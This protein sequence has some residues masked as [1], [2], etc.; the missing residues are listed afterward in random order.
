MNIRE[1]FQKYPLAWLLLLAAITAIYYPIIPRMVNDWDMDPNS[2]HGFLIPVVSGWFAYRAWPYIK[3]IPV[4]NSPWG[5]ALLVVGLLS[6]AFGTTVHELFTTRMSLVFVLAGLCLTFLGPKIFYHLLLPIGFLAFMVPIPITLYDALALPLRGLVS[7][8][9]TEGMQAVG[10]PVL[11]EGN[12]I[13]LPNVSLEVVEACSG[14]RSLISLIALGTAYAFLM[15][16]GTWRKIVLILATIPIAV[17]TNVG[18]VFI[19]G[20]LARQYGAA[21][22]E[23]FFHDFAGFMVFFLALILT[24]CTGWILNKI[25]FSQGKHHAQ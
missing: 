23:G 8:V 25:H 10:L 5:L 24:A 7:I 15:L 19:T 22:A 18:R 3:D 6:L 13:I 20:V 14:M 2:S 11:R 1:N 9:A 17:L 21:A 12:V 16:P 4:Q